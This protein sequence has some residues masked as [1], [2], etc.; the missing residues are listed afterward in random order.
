MSRA[1]NGKL[2]APADGEAS[3]FSLPVSL[4]EIPAA[5]LAIRDAADGE[6]RAA[7]AGRLEL[8][9]LERLVLDLVLAP[10]QTGIG[11][12]W[13]L[14]GTLSCRYAQACVLTLEPL[15]SEREIDLRM[16]FAEGDD[17]Q[18][19]AAEPAHDGGQGADAP[20]PVTGGVI[21]VGEAAIQQLAL[22]LDPWPRT[23]GLTLADVLGPTG[24]GDQG[25]GADEAAPP[26]PFAKLAA[27]K[28]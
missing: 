10:V 8:V 23:P 15:V 21:D 11:T 9:A 16:E 13:R 26:S 17:G 19:K 27:L 22:A 28:R 1:D 20:E 24:A 3:E 4:A 6:Q 5:G 18:D 12:V 25:D 7:V 14:E 2:P